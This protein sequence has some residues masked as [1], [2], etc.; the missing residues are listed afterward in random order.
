M[1]IPKPASSACYFGVI[2]A[3]LDGRCKTVLMTGK[4]LGSL[5]R[6][7]SMQSGCTEDD[8]SKDSLTTSGVHAFRYYPGSKRNLR[9]PLQW[10]RTL[11]ASTL[12]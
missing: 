3:V 2:A 6:T 1:F 11:P 12:I 7:P 8:S 9:G 4:Q 5:L 10:L